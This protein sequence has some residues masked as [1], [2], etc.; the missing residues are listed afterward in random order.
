MAAILMPMIVAPP[1]IWLIG[2]Q[3]G[4]VWYDSGA[5]PQPF[6]PISP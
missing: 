2:E 3:T 4:E 5:Y 6:A 1:E